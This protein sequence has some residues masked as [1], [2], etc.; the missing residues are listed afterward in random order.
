MVWT[1]LVSVRPGM[2]K[3]YEDDLIQV[4]AAAAKVDQGRSRFAYASAPSVDAWL[5]DAFGERR[6]N[7]IREPGRAAIERVETLLTIARPDL[8]FHPESRRSNQS[9]RSLGVHVVDLGVRHFL[10]LQ[11]V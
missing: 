3:A 11:R 2:S 4:V 1:I 10:E 6:A 5:D 7:A 8:S 9:D